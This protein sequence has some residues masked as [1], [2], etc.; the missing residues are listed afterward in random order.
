MISSV[1]AFTLLGRRVFGLVAVAFFGLTSC[2]V[3]A[4]TAAERFEQIKT[5][6]VQLRQFLQRMPKGG[7]LHSHLSGAVYAESFIQWAAEDGKCIDPSNGAITLPP[8]DG[9]TGKISVARYLQDISPNT[10]IEA[11]IDQLSVRNYRRGEV[12]GHD[13]FFS[14]FELFTPATWGRRGDMVAEVSSRAA[15]QNILYLE[16][17]HSLGMFEVAALAGATANLDAPYGERIDHQAVDAIVDDVIEQMDQIEARRRE[18]QNC[19]QNPNHSALELRSGCDVTV[20]YLSQVIRTLAPAQV[21]AQTLVAYKLIKADKRVVGLNFVAPE[22]HLVSLRDYRQHMN[23]IAEI[24]RQ[25]PEQRAGIALHAGEMT[26]GLVPPEHLG[27]HIREAIFTAGAKRI[28]HGID[29]AHDDNMR[30]LLETMADNKILVEINLTSNDVILEVSGTEHPLL[31]YLKFNVPVTLSTDDE[32]VAR[33]DLTHEYQRAV[34]TYDFG[35]DQ[36]KSFS[37]NALQYSF[38][39][40]AP[41][42]EN[43]LSGVTVTA[44]RNDDL[45]VKA[46]S[47]ECSQL[48]QRSPKAALQWQLEQRLHW[49]ESGL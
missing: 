11:M 32:G 31:T 19:D 14:T 2:T 13:Q 17:M 26:L 27:W 39:P 5:D 29:I 49:F 46:L 38:L 34:V 42:F 37:R 15:R 22:D 24:G 6:P 4:G 33:I 3:W 45:A 44:C 7:D 21:Y 20:R 9:D 16:L 10:S 25:F 41:L 48:M 47:K 12:S 1:V 28:G 40:G 35:Y 23:F 8:C 30:Q 36:L 43:T 18:L